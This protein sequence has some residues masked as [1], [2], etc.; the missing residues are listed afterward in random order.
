MQC[1][2]DLVS[3]SEIIPDRTGVDVANSDDA[4]FEILRILADELG[5]DPTIAEEWPGWT[6]RVVDSARQHLF[7]ILLSEIAGPLG[8]SQGEPKRSCR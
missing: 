7:S 1:Y 4:R 2:L 6:L 3:S 5:A 8:S